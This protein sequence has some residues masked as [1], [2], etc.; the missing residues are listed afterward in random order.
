MVLEVLLMLVFMLGVVGF[1]NSVNVI[2]N[3]SK[4]IPSRV[5]GFLTAGLSVVGMFYGVV[6]M[7]LR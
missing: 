5:L 3:K 2:S 6:G 4:E 7:F 1:I